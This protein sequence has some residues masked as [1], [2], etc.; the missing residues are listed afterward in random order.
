MNCTICVF[1]VQPIGAFASSGAAPGF[2]LAKLLISAVL[3]LESCGI[4]KVAVTCDG[5]PSNRNLWGYL[6]VSGKDAS[7][8]TNKIHHP[9]DDSRW[10][11]F[12]SDV[13]HLI[14]CIRNHLLKHKEGMVSCH[15]IKQN[16]SHL[17]HFPYFST[18]ET[19]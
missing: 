2:I 10:L 9:A 13:P 8:V 5:G 19:G 16:M 14:K 1:Q 12:I 6:G 11:H 15:V 18:K 17:L 3:R 4:Q 7:S